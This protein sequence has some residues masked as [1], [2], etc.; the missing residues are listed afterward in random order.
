MKSNL[1]RYLENCILGK[2]SEWSL[3][4][5]FLQLDLEGYRRCGEGKMKKTRAVIQIAITE[6]GIECK[7]NSTEYKSCLNPVNETCK[8]LHN[9]IRIKLICLF[10]IKHKQTFPF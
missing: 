10:Q 9:L 7:E 3:C 5:D 8:F 6:E 2:W 4:Y 1:F